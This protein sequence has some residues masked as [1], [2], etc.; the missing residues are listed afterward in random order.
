MKSDK[1]DFVA[2]VAL[3]LIPLTTETYSLAEKKE[4]A[5]V[6][7]CEQ[8]TKLASGEAAEIC[9][10]LKPSLLEDMNSCAKFVDGVKGVICLSSFAKH[11]TENRRT[12]LLAMM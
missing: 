11:T 7:S 2:K 9:A 4:T 3:K 10:L 12:T 5:H 8:S 6:G 1:V